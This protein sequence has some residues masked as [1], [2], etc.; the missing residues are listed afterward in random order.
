MLTPI[1][2]FSFGAVC[3]NI[4]S[5]TPY[6]KSMKKI[7]YFRP[8]RSKTYPPIRLEIIEGIVLKLLILLENLVASS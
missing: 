4:L 8:K 5:K 3:G 7:Q 2:K 1:I 6:E